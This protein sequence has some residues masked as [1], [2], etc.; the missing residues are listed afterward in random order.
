MEQITE[1][2]K[3]V[4][5][6][7]D[8]F[9]VTAEYLVNELFRYNTT[10]DKIGLVF[11]SVICVLS[12]LFLVLFFKKI[13]EWYNADSW[14][15]YITVVP[16]VVFIFISVVV[17]PYTIIDLFRWYTSPVGRAIEIIIH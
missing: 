11:W 3:T 15:F 2:V 14:W 8:K 4:E 13:K 6:L 9:C 5:S 7:C 17:I 16:S 1:S 10:M 12:I